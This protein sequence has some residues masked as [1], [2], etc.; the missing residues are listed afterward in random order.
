MWGF[1]RVKCRRLYDG[2]KVKVTDFREKSTGEEKEEKIR[3]FAL[4]LIL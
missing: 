3:K 2:Y 4:T 1:L